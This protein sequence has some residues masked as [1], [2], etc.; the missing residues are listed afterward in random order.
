MT[1]M[2]KTFKTDVRKLFKAVGRSQGLRMTG[3]CTPARNF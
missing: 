3:D 1:R 2:I